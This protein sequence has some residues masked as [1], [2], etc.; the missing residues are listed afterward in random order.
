MHDAG[1]AVDLEFIHSEALPELMTTIGAERCGELVRRFTNE[2]DTNFDVILSEACS[3]VEVAEMVHKC[4]GSAATFGAM[5]LRDALAE[6]EDALRVDRTTHARALLRAASDI[7]VQA[8]PV[9]Q[10][11]TAHMR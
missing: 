10:R 7:C 4:A 3:D 9:L 1:G 6:T 11:S 5:P 2:T 8:K